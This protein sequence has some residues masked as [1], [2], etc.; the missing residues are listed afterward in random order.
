MLDR[1]DAYELCVQSPRHVAAFLRAIHGAGP[2]VLR[3]DF[4][5]TA[6]LSRHWA[7]EP[8]ATAIAVDIDAEALARAA[9]RAK[10]AGVDARITLLAADCL[11]DAGPADPGAD[12]IFVGN[13]SIGYIHERPAL[14]RYLR[15][16]RQRL[17]HR[18]TGRGL[19]VC[20]TYGGAGA[21]RLGGLTRR[22]PGP[23][24]TTVHY[25][26]AHEHA[27]PLTG[28]VENS[29]SFRIELAGE[30]IAE[31]RRAFVYHWRL[32][33][34]AEL[35]EAMHEA[36]FAESSVFIDVNASPDRSPQPVE[37]P[38][39]LGEDWVVCIAASAEPERKGPELAGSRVQSPGYVP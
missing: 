26:W 15:A 23:D 8:N 18:K 12:V 20:D 36:G 32:W 30:I 14:V 9:Q 3:E 13:F 5:G 6:A 24:G 37:S 33:S 1:F 27:D 29:I 39:A 25:H 16:S 31:W 38:A 34:I 11:A 2:S 17:L 35:R 19:F 10:E 21:M 22:Y 28:I 4:C 7:S